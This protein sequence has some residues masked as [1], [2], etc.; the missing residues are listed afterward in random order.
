MNVIEEFLEQV[1][2]SQPYQVLKSFTKSPRV[3]HRWNVFV[4]FSAY[5]KTSRLEAMK[6]WGEGLLKILQELEE[7]QNSP[8]LHEMDAN[9]MEG[10]TFS[11]GR[12]LNGSEDCHLLPKHTVKVVDSKYHNFDVSK[13]RTGIWRCL[14]NL[15]G[16]SLSG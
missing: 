8:L 7:H 2:S 12:F 9:S 1:L 11:T 15:R 6:Q 14:R 5:V 3:K 16:P 13:G 10:I 4:K